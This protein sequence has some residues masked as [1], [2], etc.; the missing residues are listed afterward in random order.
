MSGFYSGN[1]P[2]ILAFTAA[3]LG[4]MTSLTGAFVGGLALGI[5]EQ[6]AANYM[7][8]SVPGGSAIVVFALLLIVLLAR[9]T[10]L[11][12]KTT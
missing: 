12:G 5:I 10:G 2:L 1:G 11:L 6:V 3:A 8:A 7:P 4:G 9:P